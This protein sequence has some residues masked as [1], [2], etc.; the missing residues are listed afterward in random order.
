MIL[1]RFSKILLGAGLLIAAFVM[2]AYVNGNLFIFL[3]PKGEYEFDR[4]TIRYLVFYKCVDEVAPNIDLFPTGSGRIQ[5]SISMIEKK[6]GI[7]IS[8]P[9]A[10]VC[11]SIAT[12]WGV[13][14]DPSTSKM[15]HGVDLKPDKFGRLGVVTFNNVLMEK[16]LGEYEFVADVR[17]TDLVRSNEH[18]NISLTLN[19]FMDLQTAIPAATSSRNIWM[20]NKYHFNDVARDSWL[21]VRY[22]DSDV[23]ELRDF[24]NSLSALLASVGLSLVTIGLSGVFHI[25]RIMSTLRAAVGKVFRRPEQ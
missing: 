15:H 13:G 14:G 2:L 6:S 20:N 21:L 12:A 23:Y 25:G 22:R 10:D 5:A 11:S 18:G 7:E 19:R 17:S 4:G 24:F 9:L 3:G 1:S 16:S 8:N